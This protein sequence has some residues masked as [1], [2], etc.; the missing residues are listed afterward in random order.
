MHSDIKAI[1]WDFDGVLNRNIV[2]GRFV[3]ADNLEADL[4]IPVE[5][6]QKGIFD[7]QFAHVI[8]GKRDLKTHVQDWLDQ[9][10]H[11]IDASMLLDY[12]FAKD[13][14]KD[15][16]TLGLL[17]QLAE[18]NIAQVIATNN[19][20]RR[21]AYIEEQAGFGKQV[22]HIF[23]SGRIGHA[24]PDAAFFRHVAGTIGFAPHEILLID[25]SATNIK[26]AGALGWKGYHFTEDNRAELA[27][28]LGL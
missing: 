23:S 5:A 20:T 12:W 9:S 2:N 19:E 14:L 6:F 13:D 24:K 10:G 15:P 8:S 16:Y 3:W 27:S 17:G 4:G 11:A 25:D 18:R 21:T 7:A 28:F 1:A 26:S 22:S